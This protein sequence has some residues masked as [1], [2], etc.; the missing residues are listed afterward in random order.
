MPRITALKA[1]TGEPYSIRLSYSWSLGEVRS[2]FHETEW[3][4][5]WA[6]LIWL[7]LRDQEGQTV[8]DTAWYDPRGG[9][10]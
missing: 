7:T 1:P 4:R 10:G 3:G 9:V 6:M 5:G 8:E 2:L